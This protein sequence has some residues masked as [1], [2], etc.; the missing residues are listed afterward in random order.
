MLSIDATYRLNWMGYPVFI[1]GKFV[2]VLLD[3]YLKKINFHM[4]CI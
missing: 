1:A 2:C 4:N 3:R